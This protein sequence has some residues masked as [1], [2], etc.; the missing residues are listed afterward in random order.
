MNWHGRQVRGDR[1]PRRS[2]RGP[3]VKYF[4]DLEPGEKRF[5]R[6][7]VTYKRREAG[8]ELNTEKTV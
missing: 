2:E 4:L 7:S 5:V 3:H 6:Y 1:R 8:P